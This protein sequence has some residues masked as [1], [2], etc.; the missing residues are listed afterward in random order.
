MKQQLV[1]L[2]TMP[3]AT[4]PTD[5]GEIYIYTRT[6][7]LIYIYFGGFEFCVSTLP[8]NL[9]IIRKLT[10]PLL[11][12]LPSENEITLFYYDKQLM[13]YHHDGTVKVLGIAANFFAETVDGNLVTVNNGTLIDTG[14]NVANLKLVITQVATNTTDIS[15]LNTNLATEI[16]NRINGDNTLQL[17][18]NDVSSELDSNVVRIDSDIST[19]QTN[20]ATALRGTI[21]KSEVETFTD[22]ATT[23]PTPVQYWTVN[24][25]D[26]GY[27][28]Q[29]DSTDGWHIIDSNYIPLATTIID[30]RL[31]KE[32]KLKLN[33]TS[34]TNT[35][36][37][38]KSTIETK[39]LSST[40][41]TTSKEI[42]GAINEVLTDIN[43]V[44]ASSDIGF[45]KM[46][47]M[48][49]P[50]SGHLLC[51]GAE[52]NRTT[53]SILFSIIGTTF[54]S[55]DGSTTFNLPN[56]IDKTLFGA[57][58]L[59]NN[60]STG[61]S[62]SKTLDI[63]NIP[64]H[65]HLNGIEIGVGET[66]AMTY[67]AVTNDVKN[68]LRVQTSGADSNRQGITGASIYDGVSFNT[69]TNSFSIMP[70]YAAIYYV[71]RYI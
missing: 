39:L 3:D 8:D 49:T 54:G 47:P 66:N 35:G 7:D 28:Y 1:Q 6:N 15:T 14:I 30:G 51:N 33:N 20:V 10:F 44:I 9:G 62:T 4:F 61:G 71:I 13:E 67:L 52:I 65:Q 18:I 64:P 19:L 34:N 38:T 11:P 37:E 63:H 12:T 5:T 43:T 46:W 45:I 53:Y 21:W 2:G 59:Y 70:P 60:V 25:K 23:Y 48:V 26:T 40:L 68:L 24:V 32:D 56:Y 27:T 36:D 16:T 69:Y 55:G 57:G 29:Y 50:P 22:I 42:V 17:A 41:N 58:N 31:S